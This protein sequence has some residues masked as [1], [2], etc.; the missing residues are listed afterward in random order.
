MVHEGATVKSRIDT[1]ARHCSRP[2]ASDPNDT[3]NCEEPVID[4]HIRVVGRLAGLHYG[5]TRAGRLYFYALA[6]SG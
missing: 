2:V 1:H 3:L 5:Q 6:R 4:R